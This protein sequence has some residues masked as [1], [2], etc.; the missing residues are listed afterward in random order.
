M[1]LISELIDQNPE[2]TKRLLGI[3]YEP[4][5]Q[6]INQAELANK[7]IQAKNEESKERV[8]ALGGGRKSIL[9]D[10]DEILLSLTYLRQHP[11]FEWLGLNFGVSESTA[12]SIF[13]HWMKIL[14]LILPPSLLEQSKN[15]ENLENIKEILTV[16]ELIVDTFEQTR[17]RPQDKDEREEFYSG[18]KH[19]YTFKSILTVLPKGKDIVDV[20]IGNPG[21][22]ADINLF[23]ERQDNFDSEQKFKGDKAFVGEKNIS[24][25]HKKSK[26]QELTEEEKKEDKEFSGQR[27]FIENVIRVI[28]IFRIAQQTFRLRS[29][30]YEQVISV[31]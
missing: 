12:H 30:H 15:L 20:N 19:N 24:T 9:S 8:N 1:S 7:Q 23:R 17:Q 13:H 22:K 2:R 28:R 18:Y 29:R 11:T 5:Q 16:F 4:L 14:S 27:V 6:L 3:E 31:I 10:R 25:P 26:N 21:P